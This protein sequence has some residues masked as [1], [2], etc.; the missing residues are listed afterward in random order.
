ML[1]GNLMNKDIIKRQPMIIGEKFPN[2]YQNSIGIQRSFL[3][4]FSS[5][6]NSNAMGSQGPGVSGTPSTVVPEKTIKERQTHSQMRRERE[7]QAD[8]KDSS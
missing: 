8:S 6:L 4:G 2:T 5:F 7:R 1:I 3:G